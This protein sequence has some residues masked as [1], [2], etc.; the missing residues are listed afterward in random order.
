M[1]I[2]YTRTRIQYWN[3]NQILIDRDECEHGEEVIL[4]FQ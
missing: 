2:C 1:K 3:E 4:V